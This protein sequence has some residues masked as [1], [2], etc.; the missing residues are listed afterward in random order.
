MDLQKL[1]NEVMA[2]RSRFPE[3]EYRPQDECVA[4]KLQ[5]VRYGCHCDLEPG[6]APDDCVLDYGAPNDCVHAPA[7]VA[8]GKGREA[9]HEWRPVIAAL[10]DGEAIQEGGCTNG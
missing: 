7:L 1:E 2:W 8:A 10:T 6:M 5:P 9:C 3:Y 4:L